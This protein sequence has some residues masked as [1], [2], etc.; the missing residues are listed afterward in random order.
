MR[1]IKDKKK[2]KKWVYNKA[3]ST[4]TFIIL[5]LV[6]ILVK[7]RQVNPYMDGYYKR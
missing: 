1:Y 7:Y 4:S 5:Y 6:D 2:A 3:D